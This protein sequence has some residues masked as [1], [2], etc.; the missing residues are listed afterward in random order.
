MANVT[1]EAA[2]NAERSITGYVGALST[3]FHGSIYRIECLANGKLRAATING[4]HVSPLA[5]P[6]SVANRLWTA[7]TTHFPA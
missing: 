7:K 4:S 2:S 6:K 3:Q 1:L 5:W